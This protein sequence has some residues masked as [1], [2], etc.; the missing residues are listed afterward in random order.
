MTDYWRC[1]EEAINLLLIMKPLNQRAGSHQYWSMA[2]W[3]SHKHQKLGTGRWN[4]WAAPEVCVL[5]KPEA[6]GYT[7]CCAWQVQILFISGSNIV[8]LLLPCLLPGISLSQAQLRAPHLTSKSALLC[9]STSEVSGVIS[10]QGRR[11]LFL[12]FVR[13]CFLVPVCETAQGKI[14]LLD[15]TACESMALVPNHPGDLCALPSPFPDFRV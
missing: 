9:V 4:L 3:I 5:T 10:W 13:I 2:S 15:F 1:F 14:F 11:A 6:R 8:L 7:A 12:V